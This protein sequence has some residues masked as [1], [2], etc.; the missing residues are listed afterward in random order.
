MNK[1][2]DSEKIVRNTVRIYQF[3]YFLGIRPIP[4]EPQVIV[5]PVEVSFLSC[6]F[7]GRLLDVPGWPP[8][9]I[10]TIATIRIAIHRPHIFL[11]IT[12]LSISSEVSYLSRA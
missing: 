8:T 6:I 7:L 9:S 1:C 5:V 3:A 4:T 11:G 12:F 2:P 10:L